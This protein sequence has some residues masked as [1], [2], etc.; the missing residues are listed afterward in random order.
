MATRINTPIAQFI[1]LVVIVVVLALGSKLY[2]DNRHDHPRPTPQPRSSATATNRDTT[3]RPDTVALM[4]TDKGP[5][6]IE[7]FDKD[8]PKPVD[9]FGQLAAKGYYNGVIFHRVI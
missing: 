7:L 3:S 2:G 1:S 9:N 4:N 6:K 8:A 5:I